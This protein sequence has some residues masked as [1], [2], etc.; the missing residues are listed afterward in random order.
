MLCK[1]GEW[2][3]RGDLIVVSNGL[4]HQSH[5]RLKNRCWHDS[6]REQRGGGQ[7]TV[8]QE[9]GP[10]FSKEQQKLMFLPPHS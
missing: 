5:Q 9:R 1:M 7:Q 8:H 2:K 6:M 10:A 3:Q 4:T